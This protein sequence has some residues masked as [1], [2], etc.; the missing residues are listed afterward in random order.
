MTSPQ[1]T[2]QGTTKTVLLIDDDPDYVRAIS[3]LFQGAGYVVQSAPNGA[4]GL[5][6]ARAQAPD[7]VLLDVI[8][9]DPHEGFT[10]LRQMRAIPTLAKTPVV[11]VSSLY[12]NDLPV[13]QV[14]LDGGWIPA[15]LILPKPVDPGRLLAEA[16]RLTNS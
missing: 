6:L 8:M 10:I 11:I 13:F 2:R 15:D 16:A 12:R 3:A 7:L 1:G 4:E 14:S 5:R 9:G